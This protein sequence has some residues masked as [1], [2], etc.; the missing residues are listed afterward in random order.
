MLDTVDDREPVRNVPFARIG[1][2]HEESAAVA[3]TIRTAHAPA[4]RHIQGTVPGERQPALIQH[5]RQWTHI[6]EPREID[7]PGA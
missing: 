6:A 1:W 3:A 7:H 2:M 5:I 4:H